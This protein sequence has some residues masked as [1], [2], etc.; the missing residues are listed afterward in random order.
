MCSYLLNRKL[1]P[2]EEDKSHNR[3]DKLGRGE[4]SDHRAGLWERHTVQKAGSPLSQV[5]QCSAA[6]ARCL[7]WNPALTLTVCMTSGL[8]QFNLFCV[9]QTLYSIVVKIIVLIH[10]RHLKDCLG[11]CHHLASVSCCQTHPSHTVYFLALLDTDYWVASTPL[12]KNWKWWTLSDFHSICIYC[13]TIFHLGRG[14]E[15]SR[16]IYPGMGC[17]PECWPPAYMKAFVS[18]PFCQHLVSADLE[19]LPVW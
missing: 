18:S 11:H 4:W 1:F 17:L 2:L 3:K 19:F 14:Q 6:G 7:S 10:T 16:G 12:T 5:V 8:I 15:F 9:K 13:W